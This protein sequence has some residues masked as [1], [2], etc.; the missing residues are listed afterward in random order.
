MYEEWDIALLRE[1]V[2]NDLCS[3][4]KEQKVWKEYRSLFLEKKQEL[5]DP[6]EPVHDDWVFDEFI[7]LLADYISTSTTASATD[8]EAWNW[9]HR[10]SKQQEEHSRNFSAAQ[11]REIRQ[12]LK[13]CMVRD[14]VRGK[15]ASADYL[16]VGK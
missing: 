12:A 10:L 7:P 6:M 11:S 13:K 2:A 5:K 8:R 4:I 9:V 15:V 1:F 14:I 16:L 3:P